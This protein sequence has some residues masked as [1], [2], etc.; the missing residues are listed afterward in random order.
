MIEQDP[1]HIKMQREWLI[2]NLNNLKKDFIY[3]QAKNLGIYTQI[4][5]LIGKPE[6]ETEQENKIIKPMT[7]PE[8]IVGTTKKC[9]GCRRSK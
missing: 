5:D 8:N 4:C 2:K 3:S 7:Y 6:V 1:P 9:S